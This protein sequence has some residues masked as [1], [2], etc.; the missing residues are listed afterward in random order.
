MRTLLFSS[1]VPVIPQSIF[2]S[3]RTYLL[4]LSLLYL[5]DLYVLQPVSLFTLEVRGRFFKLVPYLMLD[6]SAAAFAFVYKNVMLLGCGCLKTPRG[7]MPVEAVLVFEE[8]GE[9]MRSLLHLLAR[10]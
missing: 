8:C 3:L 1:K 10:N 5:F 4:N 6:T 7:S 9:T 2:L